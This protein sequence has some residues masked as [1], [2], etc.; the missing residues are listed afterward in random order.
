MLVSPFFYPQTKATFMTIINKMLSA[1]AETELDP[2]A[3]QLMAYSTLAQLL[4]YTGQKI[5]VHDNNIIPVSFMGLLLAPSGAG[6]G[7]TERILDK[8]THK[9]ERILE[10]KRREYKNYHVRKIGMKYGLDPEEIES[11]IKTTGNPK[12]RLSGITNAALEQYV[13]AIGYGGMGSVNIT[14]DEFGHIM[15][16]YKDTF[17]LLAQL[18][19]KGY[20]NSNITK[21]TKE[22]KNIEAIKELVNSAALFFGSSSR[23][24]DSGQNER[25]LMVML[26]DYLARRAFFFFDDTVNTKEEDPADLWEK[27][28]ENSQSV[29]S[30]AEELAALF[31]D[32]Q[33]MGHIHVSDEAGIEW[34]RFKL[35]SRAL[36]KEQ[37][38]SDITEIELL[39]RDFKTL[40]LAGI[41]AYFDLSPIIKKPHM[42]EAIAFTEESSKHLLRIIRRKPDYQKLVDYLLRIQREVSESELM[43]ALPFIPKAKTPRTELYELATDYGMRES[44]IINLHETGT[45]RRLEAEQLQET[46]TEKLIVSVSPN[47][48]HGYKPKVIKWADI[49]TLVQLSIQGKVANFCTHHFDNEHRAQANAQPAFNLL[50]CDIEGTAKIDYVTTFLS[51]DKFLI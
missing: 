38:D 35:S 31:R 41:I 5:Q 11:I 24:L 45:I 10:T 15:G 29:E 26:S 13:H 27:L 9:A 48:A 40:K 39:G 19:D 32:R 8:I 25:T 12:L 30:L 18:W 46:N 33:P 34:Q 22:N 16:R 1:L 36:A 42:E 43:E 37:Y 44:V 2:H 51:P 3:K 28:K 21:Q 49:R 7:N 6:K 17:P 20:F 50:V 23:L 47:M 14:I 4:G